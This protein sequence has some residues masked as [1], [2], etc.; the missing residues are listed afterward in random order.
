MAI[1]DDL[2]LKWKIVRYP[3]ERF[4]IVDLCMRS[5]RE[6]HFCRLVRF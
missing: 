2:N 1:L 3:V 4:E 6:E 5:T